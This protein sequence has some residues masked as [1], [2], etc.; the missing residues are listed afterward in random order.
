MPG[1]EWMRAEV[2]GV[3]LPPR[4]TPG[5]DERDTVRE[6]LAAGGGRGMTSDM[7]PTTLL[8]GGDE[9]VETREGEDERR[10]RRAVERRVGVRAV[11]MLGGDLRG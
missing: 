3:G 11:P 8:R 1:R 2:G 9:D 4:D 6:Y 5:V 7:A 10:R